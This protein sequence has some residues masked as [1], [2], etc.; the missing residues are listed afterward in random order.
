[1]NLFQHPGSKVKKL[2]TSAFLLSLL[3]VVITILLI[4]TH[5]KT[6][7]AG[8]FCNIND[9]W[10]CDRVNKSIFAELFGIPI[11]IFG[12]LYYIFVS[13]LTL[14]LARGWDFQKLIRPLKAEWLTL[15]AL[16]GCTAVSLGL[17]YYEFTILGNLWFW[18]VFKNLLFIGLFAWVYRFCQKNPHTTTNFLGFVVI[19]AL[20]GV[21]FSL[22]LSDIELFVLEGICVFCF[23][24]EIIIFII[25][26]ILIIALKQN[27]NDFL[28]AHHSAQQSG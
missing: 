6:S 16:I 18:G 24:Q 28:H 10:N 12:F 7:E 3:A 2:Y 17:L 25:T 19:M 14:G 20:F 27:K 13:V 11:A 5:Y 4:Q 15:A 22:Y 26:A 8:S 21:N 23:S 1:M 9:Y